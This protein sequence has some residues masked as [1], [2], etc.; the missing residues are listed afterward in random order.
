MRRL[1]KILIL[2]E[3]TIASI[4]LPIMVTIIFIAT[5]ARYSGLFTMPW[6][7]EFARY[8]FVWIVYLG[9]VAA[10]SRGD[11]FA[12]DVVVEDLPRK[13]R[14]GAYVLQVLLLG[15]FCAFVVRYGT[16]LVQQQVMLGQRSPTL[17]IPMWFMYSAIPL[18]CL[19]MLLQ[20]T[21][22]TADKIKNVLQEA[23][24]QGNMGS[25]GIS[26]KEGAEL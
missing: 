20:Y 14:V 5:F 21:M 19:L 17:K 25:E 12:V 18:S 11:H 9:T 13:I 6:G 23:K 2:I 16:F 26:A 24:E 8:L 1:F 10:A 4:L 7:E 3:E 22:H 15:F